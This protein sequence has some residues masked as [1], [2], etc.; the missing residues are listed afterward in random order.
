M[1][2]DAPPARLQ[3]AHHP[4]AVRDRGGRG[5]AS[6]RPCSNTMGFIDLSFSWLADWLPDCWTPELR[7][8]QA[9]PGARHPF[10]KAGRLRSTL[11]PCLPV[12]RATIRNR[13]HR[14]IRAVPGYQSRHQD[15]TVGKV[16][17]A[18]NRPCLAGAILFAIESASRF[19]SMS[20][21]HPVNSLKRKNSFADDARGRCV[22]RLA[23]RLIFTV[24][25]TIVNAKA[26]L[27]WRNHDVSFEQSMR[28]R[29]RLRDCATSR[30]GPA[31]RSGL[32]GGR[33]ATR[34]T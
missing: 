28:S 6:W 9:G 21:N 27:H 23:T 29:L 33:M 3:H 20:I 1:P 22:A 24:A 17:R 34:V 12:N 32:S 2:Q 19:V 15:V 25:C 16:G 7:Q 30:L 11:L 8:I 5:T 31:S 18:R 4:D 10:R 14:V 26:A 13:T